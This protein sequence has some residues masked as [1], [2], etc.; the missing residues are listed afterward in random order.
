MENWCQICVGV[1]AFLHGAVYSLEDEKISDIWVETSLCD[2]C[3]M[4]SLG[5]LAIKVR[6]ILIA[7]GNVTYEYDKLCSCTTYINGGHY[8]YAN[9]H[10]HGSLG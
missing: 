5:Q 9:L 6:T 3:A 8:N 1:L 10:M 4:S 2:N 7:A